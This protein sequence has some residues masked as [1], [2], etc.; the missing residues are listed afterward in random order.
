VIAA[1]SSRLSR[2]SQCRVMNVGSWVQIFSLPPVPIFFTALSLGTKSASGTAFFAS[3]GFCTSVRYLCVV[4]SLLLD[5]ARAFYEL[6]LRHINRGFDLLVQS[7][8]GQVYIGEI[9]LCVGEGLVSQQLL[10]HWQR[11][12]F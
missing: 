10:K 1:R 4:A 11:D 8:R 7:G 2:P 12:T 9:T 6:G 5:L 3:P